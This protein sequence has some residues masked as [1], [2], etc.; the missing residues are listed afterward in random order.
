MAWRERLPT[1]DLEAGSLLKVDGRLTHAT[2]AVR[3][4]GRTK[5][6]VL[7][8]YRDAIYAI[9]GTK[10]DNFLK[11]M[12]P[13]VKLAFDFVDVH[14]A[15]LI[16]DKFAGFDAEFRNSLQAAADLDPEAVPTEADRMIAL[17]TTPQPAITQVSQVDFDVQVVSNLISFAQMCDA[18]RIPG[19]KFEN[20]TA[21]AIAGVAGAAIHGGIQ[22]NFLQ[23]QEHFP[24]DAKDSLVEGSK[25]LFKAAGDAKIA[26][27]KVGAV[28]GDSENNKT[29]DAR[30]FDTYSKQAK[31]IGK[32]Y[33]SFFRRTLDK[34]KLRADW[35]QVILS[36]NTEIIE[37]N[38]FTEEVV[39]QDKAI[40]A[41]NEV[42]SVYH[43]FYETHYA[44]WVGDKT[45]LA[46]VSACD[47]TLSRLK[48]FS[49]CVACCE[50]QH[51]LQHVPS[52]RASFA[53]PG[54][55]QVQ[56]WS[57]LTASCLLPLSVSLGQTW[58]VG[59]SVVGGR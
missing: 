8:Q 50:L 27:A 26:L 56:L 51:D 2:P 32:A 40:G 47:Q 12:G 14:L 41:A 31:T 15:G 18:P 20:Y 5:I 3:L 43:G 45:F 37:E 17:C 1:P 23:Q 28:T 4:D 36:R 38:F 10:K 54:E 25:I 13:G 34:L 21:Q 52:S 24:V 49:A 46:E 29:K 9:V 6:T 57:L 53:G 7:F 22:I 44:V 42:Y 33:N 48:S 59:G 55:D 35:E 11:I 39:E 16:K 30:I 58:G 19:I